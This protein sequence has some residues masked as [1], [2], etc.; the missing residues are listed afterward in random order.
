LAKKSDKTAAQSV[1]TRSG[2]PLDIVVDGETSFLVQSYDYKNMT[3]KIIALL[4]DPELASAMG[5]KER[6]ACFKIL[7]R[8]GMPLMF[9]RFMRMF[10]N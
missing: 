10:Y 1:N 8:S 4:K 3:E 7:Q 9:S 5:A 6:P 2:G